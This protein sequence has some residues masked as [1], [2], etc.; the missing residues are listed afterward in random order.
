LPQVLEVHAE[1]W[2]Q[3]LA[4]LRQLTDDDLGRATPVTTWTVADLAAHLE[5][6]AASVAGLTPTQEPPQ[7]LASL[8]AAYEPNAAEIDDLTREKRRHT[9]SAAVAAV[10][11]R[12]IA[13]DSVLAGLV[14]SGVEVVRGRRG[15]VG[16]ADY[17]TARVIELAVHGDDL[18]RSSPGLTLDRSRPG[19]RR[20][21]QLACRALTEVLAERVPG[22]SVEVRVPPFA[23][24]QCVAGPRHTRGTPPAVV[25]LEPVTWLRLASG[26]ETW[27]DAVASGRVRASGQRTD[28]SD[29]LPL[30]R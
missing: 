7:S 27:A 26:R 3:T 25:E 11:T 16:L 14:G 20:A 15:P 8:L 2:D 22:R 17:L 5:L 6:V 10:A 21:T 19:G 29:H 23:A 12:R 1:A 13:A 24:V 18:A 30:L 28:L 9:A 4:V